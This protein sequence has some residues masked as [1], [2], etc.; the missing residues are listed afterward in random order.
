MLHSLY[1][2]RL[3][4]ALAL[5]VVSC[6]HDANVALANKGAST[7]IVGGDTTIAASAFDETEVQIAMRDSVHLH[8][9]IF[10]PKGN[11]EKLPIIFSRTP[12]GIAASGKALDSPVLADLEKDG[13][14]F[15]F[16][17]IR[18]RFKSEGD[19]VMLRP[20]RNRK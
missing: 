15:V 2:G 1:R 7:Q 4:L 19:F 13:Y 12:Y 3:V 14:I 17:D 18:G 8:T 9:S 16:Q 11:T 5:G 20:M 10:V 6:K